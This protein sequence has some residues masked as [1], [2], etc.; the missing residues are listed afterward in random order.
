MQTFS[1]EP[2]HISELE[3]RS[4]LSSVKIFLSQ[5]YRDKDSFPTFSSWGA[6]NA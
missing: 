5:I 2:L 6:Y 1:T 4:L 3:H